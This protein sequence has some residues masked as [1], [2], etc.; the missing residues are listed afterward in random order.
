MRNVNLAHG[1]AL[2][3]RRLHRLRGH[4]RSRTP[5]CWASSSR[6][7]AMAV[8]GVLLQVLI[9]RHMEGQDLRQTLV[10]IGISIV[11]PT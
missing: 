5:G 1:I 9:F 6:F 10:T 4:C 11:L 2:S 3:A 7:I 8:V